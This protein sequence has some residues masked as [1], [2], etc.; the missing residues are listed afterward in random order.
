M[1]SVIDLIFIFYFYNIVNE[2][3]IMLKI[4][5]RRWLKIKMDFIFYKV[6]L[7]RITAKWIYWKTVEEKMDAQITMDWQLLL[8]QSNR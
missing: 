6:K 8:Y 3:Q 2:K 1:S 7:S 4:Q 5:K